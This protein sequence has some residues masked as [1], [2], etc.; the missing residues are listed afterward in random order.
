MNM[1]GPTHAVRRRG[2]E[3]PSFRVREP[4]L[5]DWP[6]ASVLGDVKH[7]PLQ[8]QRPEFT[9]LEPMYSWTAVHACDLSAPVVRWVTDRRIS[10]SLQAS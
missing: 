10:R 5:W 4:F 2:S 7:L 1:E 3:L 9:S 6:F 8:T